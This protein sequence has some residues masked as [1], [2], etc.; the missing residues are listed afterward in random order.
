M[1]CGEFY[2]TYGNA[3]LLFSYGTCF[4]VSLLLQSFTSAAAFVQLPLLVPLLLRILLRYYH[5]Y[6]Y[7]HY[8]YHY[9]YRYHLLIIQDLCYSS[10]R[11]GCADAGSLC[12]IESHGQQMQSR[13]SRTEH[14]SH[15]GFPDLG[16]P[17]RRRSAIK[18]SLD[19]NSMKIDSM[20]YFTH[21]HSV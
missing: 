10:C 1:R 15:V 5:S 11:S 4:H 16:G 20:L 3:N 6:Y 19:N 2:E 18:S 21:I 13:L 8:Y 17:V 9:Y 14:P 7:Y 12:R